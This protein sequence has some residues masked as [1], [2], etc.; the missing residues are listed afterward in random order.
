MANLMRL[1]S[2]PTLRIG[3]RVVRRESDRV[4]LSLFV[5]EDPA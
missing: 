1:T 2:I 3:S 4:V 5:L